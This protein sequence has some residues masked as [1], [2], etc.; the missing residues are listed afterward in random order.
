MRCKEEKGFTLVEVL[1]SIAILSVIGVLIIT[2][3][4][5]A[6]RGDNKAQITLAIKQNGQAI[7]ENLDKTI[8]S[9]DQVVCVS[10]SNYKTIVLLKDGIY[11]RYRFVDQT[12]SANGLIRQDNPTR[13][14]G[15]EDDVN[16]FINRICNA[17]D[18]MPQAVILTDTNQVT[19]VSI[20]NGA[21][22]RNKKAGYKDMITVKFDITQGTGVVGGA[23]SGIDP[24]RFATTIELR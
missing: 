13:I 17:A 20:Q 16:I 21:F 14:A 5:R 15:T 3:F 6:L 10:S 18:P 22:I 11:S 9:A 7:L 12:S 2:I 1:V 24:V 8:R 19:G 23:S 4:S